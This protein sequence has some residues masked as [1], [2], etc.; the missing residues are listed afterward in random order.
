MNT[1][2][3]KKLTNSDLI[4]MRARYEAKKLEFDKHTLEELKEI[5]NTKKMSNTDRTALIHITNNK[6]K[7]VV[8]KN[9][10]NVENTNLIPNGSNDNTE[11]N[12]GKEE[13]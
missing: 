12:D 13:V 8:I 7:E 6:L 4:K 11:F 3:I 9:E 2:H 5:Y 10:E 1:S